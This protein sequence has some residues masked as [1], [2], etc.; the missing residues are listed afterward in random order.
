M[1]RVGA[2]AATIM[3]LLLGCGARVRG[4]PST[5]S[6]TPS[7]D[8]TVDSVVG[9]RA[10]DTAD[11]SIGTP[12]ASDSGGWDADAEAVQDAPCNLC[13]PFFDVQ[14]CRAPLDCPDGSLCTLTEG[15]AFE[16][17][18]GRRPGICDGGLY[19]VP[20]MGGGDTLGA[21][22]YSVDSGELLWTTFSSPIGCDCIGQ[23]PP[24]CSLFQLSC[25]WAESL[26]APFVDA[27]AP[28]DAGDAAAE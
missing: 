27:G 5:D 8:A 19:V 28:I 14:T 20:L 16:C 7:T 11:D 6:G 3:S 23:N 17:P 4:T 21:N 12:F 25:A 15:L 18:L 9:P 10:S 13:G 22:Y 24:P 2:V 1:A 26:C